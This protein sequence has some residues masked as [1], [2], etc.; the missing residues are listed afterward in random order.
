MWPS[1][2]KRAAEKYFYAKS[3]SMTGG[4]IKHDVQNRHVFFKKI[5]ATRITLTNKKLKPP[6]KNNNKETALSISNSFVLKLSSRGLY[7]PKRRMV[8]SPIMIKGV[9]NVMVGYLRKI[10]VDST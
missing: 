8:L 5:T 9:Y 10:R 2:P 6:R 1:W 3:D 4:P 7:P